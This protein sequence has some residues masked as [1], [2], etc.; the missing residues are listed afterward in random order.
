MVSEHFFSHNWAFFFEH[1]EIFLCMRVVI[2][3]ENM[4]GSLG[5]GLSVGSLHSC[6]AGGPSNLW[7]EAP[8]N[9][10][11]CQLE[12]F[13]SLLYHSFLA[14]W[15]MCSISAFTI[16]DRVGRAPPSPKNKEKITKWNNLICL[17]HHK[18]LRICALTCFVCS[19]K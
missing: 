15:M 3:K 2:N 9:A 11:K 18:Y 1:L 8:F 5:W 14:A 19:K 12:F 10:K 7:C 17:W 4:V 16:T 6:R 13:I